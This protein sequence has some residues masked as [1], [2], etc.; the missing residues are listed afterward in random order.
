VEQQYQKAVSIVLKCRLHVENLQKSKA[1][2]FSTSTSD[3]STPLSRALDILKNVNQQG[4]ELAN[5]IKRSLMTIPNSPLWGMTEQTKRLKLLIALEE[6]EIAGEGFSLIKQQHIQRAFHSVEFSSNI[7]VYARDLGKSF[8]TELLS[9][10]KTFFELFEDQIDDVDILSIL[11]EWTQSQTSE[12]IRFLCRPLRMAAAESSTLMLFHLRDPVV[13][14]RLMQQSSNS[15]SPLTISAD[16]ADSGPRKSLSPLPRRGSIL[17]SSILRQ[18]V[19]ATGSQSGSNTRSNAPIGGMTLIVQAIVEILSDAFDYEEGLKDLMKLAG[20]SERNS[21]VNGRKSIAGAGSNNAA[22]ALTKPFPMVA[23]CAF[24]LLPELRRMFQEYTEE[25]IQEVASQVQ[26][27]SW[28]SITTSCLEIVPS[29][30]EE[31][32]NGGGTGKDP[33]TAA[34]TDVSS[35]YLWMITALNHVFSEIIIMLNK[36]TVVGAYASDARS[37]VLLSKMEVS[38]LEPAA[39]AVVLRLLVRYL[40]ELESLDATLMTRSQAHSYASTIDAIGKYMLKSIQNWCDKL[41]VVERMQL[42]PTPPSTVF[43]TIATRINRIM[44]S[45][46]P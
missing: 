2:N 23:T 10:V 8:L 26:Q 22:S 19:P 6:Y 21:N 28:S 1:P 25:I 4:A 44:Q 13:I 33:T 20:F 32:G 31:V 14:T 27:D 5:T 15:G 16:S 43:R 42:M 34:V 30:L 45:L 17:R 37:T 35:S 41:F 7:V 40:M 9:S 12:F 38:E 46:E 18:A 11:L 39:T 3:G 29:I 24:Y 36:Q